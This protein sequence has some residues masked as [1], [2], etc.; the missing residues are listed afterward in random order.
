MKFYISGPI[1][2]YPNKNQP[3]FDEAAVKLR[4]LGHTVLN[5]FE[6]DQVEPCNPTD[7]FANMRRDIK[8]IP[9]ADGYLLL[10]GWEKSKGARVEVFIACAL[11][12]ITYI[13]DEEGNLQYLPTEA[14]AVI[15]VYSK[16]AGQMAAWTE[17]KLALK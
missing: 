15:D 12:I 10:P 9:Q 6:L 3:A 14:S 11:N 13:F 4:G 2:G 5:P 7:W 17:V 8:W 1:S 16:E